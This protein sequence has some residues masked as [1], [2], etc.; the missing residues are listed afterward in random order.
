M[1]AQEFQPEAG[2]PDVLRRGELLADGGGRKSRGG[3]AERRVALDQRDR[4]GKPLDA[5]QEIGDRRADGAR[6]PRSP[7]RKMLVRFNPSLRPVPTECPKKRRFSL[8][9]GSQPRYYHAHIEP[10]RSVLYVPADKPHAITKARS[11]PVDAVILDLEDSVAPEERRGARVT[12]R[13]ARRALRPRGRSSYQRT[14]F[15]MGDRGHPGRDRSWSRRHPGAEG[16]RSG[17]VC[18]VAEAFDQADALGTIDLWAMVETPKAL[19]HL[20]A[21]RPACRHRPCRSPPS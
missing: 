11:L 7:H 8:H 20:A 19:L 5:L 18:T 2:E 9:A 14:R 1:V 3:G 4:A 21:H 10:R 13:S 15:G 6:L 17:R 12:S 16:R